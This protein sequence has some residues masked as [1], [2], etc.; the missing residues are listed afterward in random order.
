MR[1]RLPRRRRRRGERA[2]AWPMPSQGL[3][4]YMQEHPELHGYPYVVIGCA[5]CMLGALSPH[6]RDDRGRT[7]WHCGFCRRK[8]LL[9]RENGLLVQS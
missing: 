9:E 8:C 1:L 2:S 4:R 6:H 3:D 7:L 5:F